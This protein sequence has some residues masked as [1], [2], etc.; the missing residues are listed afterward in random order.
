[1]KEE[2][3]G[4]TSAIGSNKEAAI[5]RVKR[6]R[7]LRLKEWNSMKDDC[8]FPG[9]W[10]SDH[11]SLSL[12]L[13]FHFASNPSPPTH[14]VLNPNQNP[15]PRSQPHQNRCQAPP[16][17][18][19]HYSHSSGHN[20]NH[21]ETTTTRTD[22]PKINTLISQFPILIF[23]SLH[24][25]VNQTKSSINEK[26]EYERRNNKTN[27]CHWI[28]QGGSDHHSEEREKSS[29]KGVEPGGGWPLIPGYV[30]FRSL[31][32]IISSDFSLC[33]KPITT[34]PPRS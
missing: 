23:L 34:H 26:I 31:I 11:W 19:K 5:T 22:R 32:S 16:I 20:K 17:P 14:L 8:R 4:R 13:T 18:T 29:I 12:A 21:Q 3:I 6:E 2:T 33:F 24:F 1:M 30:N 28:Q 15:P 27:Q 9:T 7:N 25:L 10:I